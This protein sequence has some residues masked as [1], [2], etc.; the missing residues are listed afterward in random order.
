MQATIDIWPGWNVRVQEEES[1]IVVARTNERHARQETF[2]LRTHCNSK[3]GNSK[4]KM[5]QE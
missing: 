2:N 5:K 4:K 1:N 3:N